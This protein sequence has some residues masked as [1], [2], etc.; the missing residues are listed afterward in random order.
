MKLAISNIAWEQH[1]DP[2]ILAL[3]REHQVR[4]IEV[5][6]T[7]LWPDWEGASEE[8]A[9]RYREFLAKEGFK[10]PAMQAI[11]FSKPELQVF[12]PE[13]HPAFLE[14]MKLLADIAA[15]FGAKTL[16]FGA[17]KNRIRGE[18]SYDEALDKAAAFFLQVAEL[19]VVR[20][21][22]IGLEHNP[23]EYGCDFV[24]DVAEAR[25]LVDKVNH[26]GF[27]LHL[28]SAGI[29][30]SGEDMAATIKQADD[31]VHYHISEPML[32]PIWQGKVD[33][34][35][36]FQALKDID[37]RHWVSIEMKQP[38]HNTALEQ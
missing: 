11:L 16:V 4:G 18:I 3:L 10:I 17:P 14:H 2:K 21:C 13:S 24:V 32:A 28:D 35:A 25:A 19:C 26:P 20:G 31:F 38:E 8:G 6:P 1:D 27:Q 7:K 9:V 29:Y 23:A 12:Q 33:H 37:Y 36:A 22:A 30:M 15:G 5:A 34:K